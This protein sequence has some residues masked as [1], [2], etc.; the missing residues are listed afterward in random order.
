MIFHRMR[1][2]D[3]DGLDLGN[4]VSE[5]LTAFA[6]PSEAG[7]ESLHMI[8]HYR[9]QSTRKWKESEA[10]PLLKATDNVGSFPAVIHDKEKSN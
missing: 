4:K 7:I 6:C 8:Y 10:F 3:I 2:D 1:A 9:N 5:W